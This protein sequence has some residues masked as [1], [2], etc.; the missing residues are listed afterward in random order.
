MIKLTLIPVPPVETSH[1][2]RQSDWRTGSDERSR[3]HQS[4]DLLT[5][6]SFDDT[7]NYVI[8]AANIDFVVSEIRGTLSFYCRV[9]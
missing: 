7:D 9:V 2:L 1:V 8:P 4:R 3:G 6:T 5:L